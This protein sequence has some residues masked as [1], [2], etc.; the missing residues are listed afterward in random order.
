MTIR[1]GILGA[2]KIAPPVVINPSRDNADFEVVAVAA[3][4]IERAKAYAAEH[5]I[6]QVAKDYE[7]LIARNGFGSHYRNH[8]SNLDNSSRLSRA[9]HRAIA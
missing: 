1:I 2:A 8:P 6:P 4:D 5:K 7:A 9:L 3:R